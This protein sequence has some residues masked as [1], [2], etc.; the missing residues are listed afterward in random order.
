F[1]LK[2]KLGFLLGTFKERIEREITSNLDTL[3][4]PQALP[5]KQT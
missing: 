4:A 1:E 3:L 2:A 5:K